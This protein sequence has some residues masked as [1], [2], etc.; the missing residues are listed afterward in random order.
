MYRG[1]ICEKAAENGVLST[2][3]QRP[4]YQRLQRLRLC[5]AL[6]R[7]VR[8]R[9]LRAHVSPHQYH[10]LFARLMKALE[11]ANEVFQSLD[12]SD[13]AKGYIIAKAKRANSRFGPGWNRAPTST[14]KTPQHQLGVWLICR[15]KCMRPFPFWA[16]LSR[17]PRKALGHHSVY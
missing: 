7:L 1:T 3:P 11:F 16:V 15:V 5:A 9:P 10:A 13:E 2:A 14:T 4:P 17:P 6:R 12:A 8:R